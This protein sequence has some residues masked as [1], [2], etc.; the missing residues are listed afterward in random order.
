MLNAET[1]VAPDNWQAFGVAMANLS[2]LP[3]PPP[4]VEG[5]DAISKLAAGVG[6]IAGLDIIKSSG[7]FRAIFKDV[8]KK[9]TIEEMSDQTIPE[10]SMP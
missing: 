2:K 5:R 9:R 6:A 8:F 10:S 7:G 4:K 3:P 1:P